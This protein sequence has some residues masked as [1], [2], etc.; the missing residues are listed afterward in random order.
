MVHDSFSDVVSHRPVLTCRF[1]LTNEIIRDSCLK[2]AW[3]FIL[4]WRETGREGRKERVEKGERVRQGHGSMRIRQEKDGWKKGSRLFH[5][6][7]GCSLF[8]L[9][10][11]SLVDKKSP[12]DGKTT[13][14][15][16]RPK[17]WKEP[18]SLMTS[19]SCWIYKLKFLYF[20]TL[21]CVM[22]SFVSI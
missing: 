11:L 18:K 15:E 20:H 22:W 1:I 10:E 17:L 5:A 9:P 21:C 4:P 8:L 16:S 7:S 6:K 12:W 19:L 13:G 3:N 14:L 2:P